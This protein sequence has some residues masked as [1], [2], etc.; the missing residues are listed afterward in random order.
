MQ[1]LTSFDG[2]ELACSVLGDGAD[3]LLL[4]GFG[5]DA[6]R[7]W[8][9]PGIAD[10][11]VAAG[12]RVIMYD[13]RG[14]GASDK[15]HDSE[16]YALPAMERDAQAVLDH[17][18]VTVVDVVGYSMGAIVATRLVPAEPRTRR[19]VLG[20]IG[21]RLLS[22]RALR[23]DR[24]AAALAAAPGSKSD[25]ASARAFRH[26]AER[27]GNDLDALAAI[28]RT[29]RHASSGKLADIH[30]PTL[31]AVGEGDTLAGDPAALAAAIPDAR[32]VVVPGDHL[33]AVGRPELAD[34]IVT[35]LSQ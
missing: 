9:V 3:T 11:L 27:G 13:A 15:P 17:L 26:F 8:V 1:R 32:A 23:R 21:G 6:Q 22:G 5:A 18:G 12:R 20:G 33:T 29:P 28:M 7:N 16:A 2:L 24:I 14:H 19:L 30:V 35:F 4:H 34:A 25:D 31:V 10:A